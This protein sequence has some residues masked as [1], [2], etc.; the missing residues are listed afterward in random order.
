MQVDVGDAV[1]GKLVA[2]S[3]ILIDV[4]GG[5]TRQLLHGFVIA[6]D[7]RKFDG[8]QHDIPTVHMQYVKGEKRYQQCE[9]AGVHVGK[10]MDKN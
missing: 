7:R 9:C 10:G 8:H 4:G 6:G 1:E 5:Q 2:F 3:A